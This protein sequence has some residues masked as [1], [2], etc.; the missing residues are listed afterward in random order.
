MELVSSPATPEVQAIID[1]IW[2]VLRQEVTP[3]NIGQVMAALLQMVGSSSVGLH[4]T[5]EELNEFIIR[6]VQIGIGITALL[7]HKGTMN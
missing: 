5:N 2:S 6:N 1:H 3:D 4:M 7:S